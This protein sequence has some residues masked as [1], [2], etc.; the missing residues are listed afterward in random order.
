MQ[1][2]IDFILEVEKLKGITRKTLVRSDWIAMR[3]PQSTAGN[4]PYFAISLGQFA[5]FPCRYGP[6]G[7]NAA[8]A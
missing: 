4:L 3:T 6:R 2:I 5:E 8:G 7:A 1:Q